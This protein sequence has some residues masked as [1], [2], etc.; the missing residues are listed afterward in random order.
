MLKPGS[1]YIDKAS[2]AKARVKKKIY[3]FSH[4]ARKIEDEVLNFQ[5]LK[6]KN[7]NAKEEIDRDR[8]RA[9]GIRYGG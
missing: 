6:G 1:A 8:R 5:N 9:F 3:F 2:N 4:F 7:R